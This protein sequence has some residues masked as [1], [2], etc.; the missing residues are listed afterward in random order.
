MCQMT[1]ARQT[2][3]TMGGRAR[4]SSGVKWSGHLRKHSTPWLQKAAI[5]IANNT[6]GGVPRCVASEGTDQTRRQ[7]SHNA[8]DTSSFTVD[9]GNKIYRFVGIK[10]LSDG[11]G[12]FKE[13]L[14]APLTFVGNSQSQQNVDP[15]SWR[16]MKCFAPNR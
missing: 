10:V 16:S 14:A 8:Q 12:G 2:H 11:S 7:G 13:A 4:G 1:W 5:M 3:S 15:S 6:P 9:R